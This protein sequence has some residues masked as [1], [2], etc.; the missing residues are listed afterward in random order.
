MKGLVL[1]AAFSAGTWMVMGTNPAGPANTLPLGFGYAASSGSESS[2]FLHA[3]SVPSS[4]ASIPAEDLNEVVAQYCVRCHNDRMQI[5]NLSLTGFDVAAAPEQAEKAEK[6]INKLRMGMMPPPGRRG[7]SPDTVMA[8]LETLESQLDNAAAATPRLG[9][10]RFQRLT[11]SEYARVVYDMLGLE[12]DVT[13]WLPD[14]VGEF[15][16]LAAGQPLSTTLVQAYL[17]AATEVARRAVGNQRG[18]PVTSIYSAP[19]RISQHASDRPEGAPFGTRGGMVVAHDFL[20]D[21]EYVFQA[22]YMQGKGNNQ[23]AMEDLDISIDGEAAALLMLE[24]SAGDP[25]GREAGSGE[26]AIVRSEPIFVRAGQRAVSAAF[27]KIVDGPY[28]DRFTPTGWSAAGSAPFGYGATALAHLMEFSVE[29]PFN[30]SGVSETPSRQRIFTCRPMSPEEERPCAKSILTSL[31]THAYRRPVTEDDVARLMPLYD[32]AAV[33]DGFEIGVRTGLQAILASPGF[34]FRF[35]RE[36]ADA[37]PGEVYRLS[38]LELATRLSFFLWASSPDR[39]LLEVAGRGELSDPAVLERQVERMLQ[40][41]RS[42]ALATRFAHQWL[43][44]QDVGRV[45]PQ[46]FRYP[47][48]SAQLRDDLVRETHLFFQHMVQE[49]RS[50]IEFFD[51]DYTFVNERVARHYGIEGVYGD[52]FRR[53]EY[54]NDGRRGILGHGSILQLTSMATR[55]SPVLRGKWVMEVLMGS[56]PP[57]PPPDVPPFEA[58]PAG[59]EGRRL[60]TAERMAMH[61]ASPACSSCHNVIDPIGLA[62]ENFDAAGAWRIREDMESIDTQGELYDGTPVSSASELAE[63]L[64]RRSVPVMRNF[65]GSLLSYAMGRSSDYYDQPTIRAI[66]REAEANDYKLSAFIK[67]VVMSDLFQMKQTQA[68]TEER[69]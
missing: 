37:R 6:V 67:G 49:D 56:P 23:A 43:R 12:V 39:E 42:E 17:E 46:A 69:N 25:G 61:R 40:D 27:V 2:A 53:V 34:L 14:E 48:F 57:A 28:D 16:N 30:V 22:K 3:P 29:G 31:A 9:E 21:G 11:R 18:D 36:P 5:G 52:E 8:L 20:A 35:E 63:I 44:L 45:W 1:I 41:S 15:D 62:L 4:S 64:V 13:R 59:E 55:T 33:E 68:P 32:A 65:T 51:A 47:N 38:D 7:P 24:H 19:N 60:T 58:S 10:R 66:T 50:M 54:P 26:L